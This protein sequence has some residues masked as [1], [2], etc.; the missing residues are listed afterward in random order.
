[1]G[2]L[3]F[4]AL[5][6]LF[7]AIPLAELVVL[8]AVENRFGLATTIGLIVLT[9][10]LGAYLVRRQGL[11]LLGQVRAELQR[12]AFPG[13]ELGHGALLLLGGALLLTPGFLTDAVGLAL[14]APSFREL[15]RLRVR[16]YLDGRAVIR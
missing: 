4:M 9:G 2:I 14:M 13:Q 12:G 7:L 5:P 3:S 15:V 1:M 11:A 10:L 16:W 8:A 6:V